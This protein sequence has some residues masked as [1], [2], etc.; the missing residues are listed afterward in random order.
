M[1][2]E[3]YTR[4]VSAVE[5]IL[6]LD[7]MRQ[8]VAVKELLQNQGY[9]PAMA[10]NSMRKTASV[11]NFS[12]VIPVCVDGF[13]FSIFTRKILGGAQTKLYVKYGIN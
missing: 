11:P 9:S 10:S 8:N 6:T 12:Q 13:V 2:A 5:G 4:G 3:K 7:R 1:F